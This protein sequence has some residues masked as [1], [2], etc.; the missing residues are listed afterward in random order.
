MLK[1]F[2]RKFKPLELLSEEEVEAIHQGAL[3]VLESTGMRVEHERALELYAKGGCQVDLD[4]RRVR[5][6]PAL[7]E[8]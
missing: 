7:V 1:G 6:P 3:Y 8:Q 2:T 4:E 5:F